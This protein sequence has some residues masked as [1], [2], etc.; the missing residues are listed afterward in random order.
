[1]PNSSTQRPATARSTTSKS[2][3]AAALGGLLL[4]AATLQAHDHAAEPT[5]A[6]T[7]APTAV[8]TAGGPAVVNIPADDPGAATL[9]ARAVTERNSLPRFETTVDFRFTD[10]EPESGITFV[11]QIVDDAGKTYKPAH[12]DHGNGV[13]AADVDGDGRIDLYFTSQLG[14]NELWLN[15][16]G[17][18]FHDGT[19]AGHVGLDGR[20]AVSAS[21]ADI[22]NDGDEDL[23]VTTV[24]MGNTLFENDGKGHFRDISKAA[25]VDYVGHSSG[26]VFLDY[27]GDGLLDLF[28]VNVGSY[29]LEAKGRGGYYLARADAFGGHLHPDRTEYSVLYRN[30]G[31]NRF[32]DVSQEAGLHDGSWSG[33]AVVTDFNRDGKP[34][35]YVFNMQGDNHYYENTGGH[36][37]DKTAS[38]FPK[39]PW[40]AMGG[41]AFDYD[42]DGDF[43][44]LITDMHSDMVK[45]AAP[46]EERMKIQ[47]EGEGAKKFFDAP[48][49]NIFGNAFWVNDGD[50]KFHE[51]SLELGLENYWPWGVSVDDLNADGFRDVLITASMNFPYRYGV[52]S[53][54]INNRGKGFLDAEMLLGIEPRRDGRTRKEWFTLDC[55][56]PEDKLHSGCEGQSGKVSV[57]G[58]LGSRS[59][60]IFDLD[61]D[62]DLD[63]VT[64]ELNDRPM[65]LVSD[66]AQRRPLSWLEV[67]LVGTKSNRDGIGAEVVVKAGGRTQTALMDGATGYLAHGVLPLYFGLGDAKTIES[68]EV[69]WPSGAMQTVPGPIKPNHTI[70]VREV[71]ASGR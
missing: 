55:A 7:A 33:D 69:R 52:N 63:I 30:L 41:K 51:A 47:F 65:V 22:D 56:T 62:G 44:L 16:G 27:D 21:F 23:Y 53:L 5:A 1:M 10:R 29:T 25:G 4:A 18:R 14:R 9:A 32:R 28:L 26:A 38:L 3:I 34:D 35:L 24:R 15:D 36:F 70:D 8:P 58:T 66:L 46:E 50:G 42:N 68:V 31:G 39:T 54:L 11:H 17:G 2:A 67:R 6:P 12:Y 48:E 60:V 37:V 45:L 71:A 59:S 19:D 64:N 13:A 57:T 20:I 49:N 61:D 43:D 40:G